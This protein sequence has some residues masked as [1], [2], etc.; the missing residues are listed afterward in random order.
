METL[1]YNL[2]GVMIPAGALALG[3]SRPALSP[4]SAAARAGFIAVAVVWTSLN[5][6]DVAAMTREY[7]ERPPVD[8]RQGLV[9]EMERRGIHSA[10]AEYRFAYHLS[11]ISGERV[12]VSANDYVRVKAYYEEAAASRAPTLRTEAC[13]GGDE[14]M[15]GVFLCR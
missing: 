6:S 11:F 15:A 10:W 2:L 3:L 5:A 4:L 12:R 9:A 7:M 13:D 14:L 1:R 8:L